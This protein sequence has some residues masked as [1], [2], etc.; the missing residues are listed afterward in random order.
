MKTVPQPRAGQRGS[1]VMIVFVLLAIAEIIFIV[2]TRTLADLKR[3][4]ALIE[5]RQQ[6]N[7]QRSAPPP[8]P[9]PPRP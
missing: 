9:Q 3:E 8:A 5:Q 2:N 4:L 6:Q 7:L 1:A